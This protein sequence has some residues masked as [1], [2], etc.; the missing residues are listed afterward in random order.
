MRSHSVVFSDVQACPAQSVVQVKRFSSV[1][2]V[3]VSKS[4][5]ALSGVKARN[6]SV[7]IESICVRIVIGHLDLELEHM[8]LSCIVHFP[9]FTSLMRELSNSWMRAMVLSE[10]RRV[11]MLRFEISSFDVD[12]TARVVQ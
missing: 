5:A 3:Y 10:R 4:F 1:F 6:S 8:S 9:P 12:T 11:D 7:A 2:G